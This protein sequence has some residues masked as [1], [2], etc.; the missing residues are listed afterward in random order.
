[1]VL[2]KLKYFSVKILEGTGKFYAFC[3]FQLIQKDSDYVS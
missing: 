3:T 1:M 2:H